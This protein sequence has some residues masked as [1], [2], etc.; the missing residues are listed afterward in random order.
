MRRHSPDDFKWWPAFS[1]GAVDTITTGTPMPG[2]PSTAPD[3]ATLESE[4]A[5]KEAQLQAYKEK[6]GKLAKFELAASPKSYKPYYLAKN[7]NNR[8]QESFNRWNAHNA[9][10]KL[11]WVK[12]RK[13]LDKNLPELAMRMEE[14]KAQCWPEAQNDKPLLLQSEMDKKYRMAFKAYIIMMENQPDKPAEY[15]KQ[16]TDFETYNT[17]FPPL[18]FK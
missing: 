17:T 16:K 4:L 1:A 10:R 11:L 9:L 12:R 2:A 7:K 15:T 8:A 6:F 13:R 14:L 18:H 3:I 5:N